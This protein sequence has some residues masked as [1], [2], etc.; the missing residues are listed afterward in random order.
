Q[1]RPDLGTEQGQN[2]LLMNRGGILTDETAERLPTRSEPGIFGHTEDLNGDGWIDISQVNLKNG[3]V[4]GVPASVP[5]IRVLI[6]DGAGRFPTSLEQPMPERLQPLS[7]F[8][9]YSIEHA[10]L[11]GDGR[12]D[13]Y[14]INW[15][16][17]TSGAR[18]GVFVNS[19]NPAQL[20]PASNI[21]FP[22]LPVPSVDGDGDHPVS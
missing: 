2:R 15:G 18:D 6:N 16:N 14:V 9:T 3:L 11:N 20:F 12:L 17:A 10:D 22:E 13:L 4:P 8:G 21:Y 1:F 19:G 7:S 5:S